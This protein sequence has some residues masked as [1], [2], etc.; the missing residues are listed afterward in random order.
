M[1]ARQ[2]GDEFVVILEEIGNNTR[3]AMAQCQRRRAPAGCAVSAL[4]Y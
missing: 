2:G 4:F 1:V 3:E